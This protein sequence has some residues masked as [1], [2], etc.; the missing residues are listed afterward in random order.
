MQTKKKALAI[1]LRPAST[2]S[3]YKKYRGNKKTS[4]IVDADDKN[5]LVQL[6]VVLKLNQGVRQ[7]LYIIAGVLFFTYAIACLS[8]AQAKESKYT[9]TEHSHSAPQTQ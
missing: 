4:T 9:L 3:F 5:C 6:T 8:F 7:W 2:E 1:F